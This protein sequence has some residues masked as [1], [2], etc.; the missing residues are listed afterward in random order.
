MT[1]IMM[2]SHLRKHLVHQAVV[3][4]IEYSTHGSGLKNRKIKSIACS[5]KSAG[6]PCAVCNYSYGL[7]EDGDKEGAKKWRDKETV[8]GQCVVVDS[9]IEINEADDGNP[10]KKFYIPYGMKEAIKEAIMN[11]IIEDPLA[12]EFVIKKTKNSGGYAS[13]DKSFFNPKEIDFPEEVLEAFDDGVAAL[14][15]LSECV[16]D[17]TTEKDMEK[18]LKDAKAIYYEE[19]DDQDDDQ[20]DD[21]K[22]SNDSGDDRQDDKDDD[23]KDN[24]DKSSKK[25]SGASS[26]S[27]MDR[28]K[29]RKKQ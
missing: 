1:R 12:H 15:D 23:D 5:Y 10:I 20:D 13:Y 22:S 9:P 6:E 26:G 16:P 2:I 14:H 3:L 25:T 19:D 7:Y 8:I 29:N 24:D 17:A 18:W 27:V 28:I 4:W 21:D 11:G